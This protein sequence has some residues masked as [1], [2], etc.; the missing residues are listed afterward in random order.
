[1][2]YG[3]REIRNEKLR[4]VQRTTTSLK[5]LSKVLKENGRHSMLSFLSSVRISVVNDHCSH[6]PIKFSVNVKDRSDKLRTTY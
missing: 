4:A 5:D 1:M 6:L 2:V 3:K